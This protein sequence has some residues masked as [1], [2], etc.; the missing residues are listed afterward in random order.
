MWA[1]WDA[2]KPRAGS[3]AY[4]EDRV[5]IRVA[6]SHRRSDKAH[7][8]AR[9]VAW[10]LL[11][12]AAA[13]GSM[14]AL[15]GLVPMLDIASPLMLH[16][17]AVGSIAAT[18]LVLPFGRGLFLASGIGAVL[19]APSLIS[20]DARE[21]P[22]DMRQPWHQAG[23]TRDRVPTL[24]LLSLNTWHENRDLGRLGAYI[25]R[26]DAD[27]VV[28]SEFGPD[29]AGLLRRL[30]PHY[31]YQVHCAHIWA[32]SQALISRLPFHASGARRP[33]LANPPLVWAEF[34][35][36]D[37][38]ARK[39]T[40]FGTHIYRPSRRYD[41]HAA[42]L[43]GLAHIV[44]RTDGATV[45]AGDFNMTRLS[46]SF[47]AFTQAAGLTA[48]DRVLANWPAWP[49]PLPQV[50]L[51]HVFVSRDIE[52]LDQRLGRAVGSDHLPLWSAISLPRHAT[53]IARSGKL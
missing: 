13:V 47:A 50:Q 36:G 53:Q 42:Q 15:R 27:V 9:A 39:L 44:Q 38:L 49:L 40:V 41:W 33:S 45:V 2:P 24:R 4:R 8:A 22:R 6:S 26:A 20:L 19:V 7:R 43:A 1:G 28:L 3:S 51:D 25:A 18:S 31:P 12:A 30:R 35:F 37:Q 23:I 34:R 21:S 32:C 17:L 52:V 48:P 10:L 11:V 16:A 29:K 46:Q 14:T 5:R